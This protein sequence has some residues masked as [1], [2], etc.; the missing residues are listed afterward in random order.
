MG[1]DQ[2]GESLY[3]PALI[4]LLEK[5]KYRYVGYSNRISPAAFKSAAIDR[6]EVPRL[7]VKSCS[8][9]FASKEAGR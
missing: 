6:E 3:V 7:I 5:R 4:D 9:G 2:A 8:A 1:T